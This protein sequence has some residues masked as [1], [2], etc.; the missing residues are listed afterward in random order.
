MAVRKAVKRGNQKKLK[1]ALG[2]M[3]GVLVLALAACV[4]FLVK[5]E[6]VNSP[7]A[8]TPGVTESVQENALEGVSVNGI[9]ISGMDREQA[10]KATAGISDSV[11]SQVNISVSVD[12][13]LH[14]FTA[15]EL[16]ITTDYEDVINEALLFGHTGSKEERKEAARLAKSEGKAFTVSVRP[17]REAVGSALLSLKST[18]DKPATDATCTFTPWGHL[19]DG[20]PYEQDQQKMIEAAADNKMWSRPELVRIPDNEMPNKLRYQFWKNKKYVEGYKPADASISRF[21]YTEGTN[22]LSV[23]TEAVADS[24]V[25]QLQSGQYSIIAAPVTPVEP[26]VSLE[27]LKKN[28]Q[29]VAS[30]SSS[31]AGHLSYNR[32]WNVAKLSG[33]VNG[34]VIQPGETWSIN[35]TAGTR[36]VKGGWKEASGIVDG[37]Y[38]DQPGGGVCQI[39]STTYNA[40]I[41]AALDI[42]DSTHHS[43]P[44]DYIP[45]GLDATIS[46]GGPD[47]KIRNPYDWPVYIISYVNPKDKSSTVE[48]YGPPVVHDKYG[49]VILNFSFKDGG[50]FGSAKM[51]FIYNVKEGPGGKKLAP[52]QS[53]EYAQAR[54]GRKVE[55]FIHYLSLDGKE[56]AKKSFHKYSWNPKDGK[57][58]VNGPDPATVTPTP[59]PV[60]PTPGPT[61]PPVTTTPSTTPSP[62]P[63]TTVKP[64]DD[65][66]K[67]PG[68][69]HN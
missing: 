35:D 11:L 13:E 6:K 19:A 2:V 32:N 65:D 24:V 50:T 27:A 10:L 62:T 28:T 12:G 31:Y 3:T 57:T 40:A 14:S 43:I 41:R 48:V 7:I 15:Q 16:G 37:G 55:T 17:D 60:T 23:D 69:G 44:S 21:V 54:P 63:T 59:P 22:G 25:S 9:D 29:L 5:N 20:T 45:F 68:Q 33:I 52:G 53:F 4:I 42:K 56:L 8:A 46:S 47:L 51:T 39:S 1:V 49:E 30:W 66:K 34:T 38:V 18:L 67:N 36:T 64:E 26:A 61:Q 58:Y